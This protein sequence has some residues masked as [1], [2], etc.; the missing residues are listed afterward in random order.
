MYSDLD[1]TICFRINFNFIIFD[2][3]TQGKQEN[4]LNK[5]KHENH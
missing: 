2:L 1:G 5:E 3:E 4:L